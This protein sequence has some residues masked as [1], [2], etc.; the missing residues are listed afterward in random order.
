M[1]SASEIS[2]TSLLIIFNL[3]VII[4]ISFGVINVSKL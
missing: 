2:I 1:K 3:E 4:L